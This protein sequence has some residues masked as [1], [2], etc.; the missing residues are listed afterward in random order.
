MIF[1]LEVTAIDHITAHDTAGVPCW[2]LKRVGWLG[3]DTFRLQCDVVYKPSPAPCFVRSVS[4]QQDVPVPNRVTGLGNNMVES[5]PAM[6][7]LI[8][9]LSAT[10]YRTAIRLKSSRG[11]AYYV[12]VRKCKRN[13]FVEQGEFTI[14]IK[15]ERCR[16]APN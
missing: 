15:P 10:A 13:Y 5:F 6:L 11:V 9:E 3:L 7:G 8:L 14:H 12:N 4:R 16:V 1:N 2:G